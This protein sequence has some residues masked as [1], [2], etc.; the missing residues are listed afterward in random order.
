MRLHCD[1]RRPVPALHAADLRLR[2][3]GAGGAPASVQYEHMF[4]FPGREH[5]P[6]SRSPA[7]LPAGLADRVR[8]T[9]PVAGRTLPV[10][11]PLAPL[12]PGGSLR[13]GTTT[14]VE[15]QPG[16]GATTLALALLARGHRGGELVCRGRPARSRRG[17]G[18]RAR[19]RSAPGRLRAPSGR[20]LGGG[21]RRPPLRRRR[22]PGAPARPGRPDRGTASERA[23]PATARPRW[24]C[25]S[26]ERAAGPRAGTWRCRWARSSGRASGRGHGYLRG[27]RAEVRVSGRRA[28]GRVG[29]CS[30]WLPA[31]SGAVAAVAAEVEAGPA[32]A[33][34]GGG[35]EAAERRGGGEDSGTVG[36][37]LVPR[38]P[39]GG[40]RGEEARR[41]ARVVAR[42]GELC[43]WVHPVRL[44]VCA[45][46]ARG[47]AR[48]FGGE[49]AVV[50][51][52]ADEPTG[53]GGTVGVADGLFAA[54]LAARS[55]LIVPPGGTADFLAPWSV[56]TLAR[57]DLAVTL[58][59]LGITT[60]GQFAALPAANVSD[61][62]GPDA[63]A[64]HAVA[65]GESGELAGLRD[66]GHRAAA[67]GGPG[68]GPR[69]GRRAPAALPARLLRRRRPRP[70]GAPPAPSSGCRS[71]WASRRC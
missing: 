48:F 38:P 15:G 65:R 34:P 20:R 62:F 59:R 69:P 51:R 42:A 61:R 52:L 70:T 25:C 31:G 11:A 10:P 35:P 4:A 37:H 9:T 68:R 2:L 33:G 46:P 8:P 58:Q 18:G 5:P 57:P 16:H 30:L 47:P 45:L 13:R 71:A 55:E 7:P 22:R 12:F 41:F 44:G 49:E 54:V 17:G 14:T 19:A 66:K 26:R 60:L 53:R 32:D 24:W 40:G 50:S 29:E 67:P 1:V 6:S 3:P 63:A 27:R 36:R 28:A 64:C 23:G 21:G 43:P 56:A 39:R